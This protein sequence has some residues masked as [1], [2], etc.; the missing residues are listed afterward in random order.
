MD[1]RYERLSKLA[2]EFIEL[3]QESMSGMKH[4]ERFKYVINQDGIF[5]VY[6]SAAKD[7]ILDF[8]DILAESILI[9]RIKRFKADKEK[10]EQ[11]KKE[12]NPE[13]IATD[14]PIGEV[15]GV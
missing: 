12:S 5:R 11:A 15:Q 7:T 10:K 3:K 13:G 1:T 14:W 8:S 4:P 9:A 2:K 6:Q